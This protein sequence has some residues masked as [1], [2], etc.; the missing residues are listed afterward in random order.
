M[1]V[2][3]ALAH[4]VQT[5]SKILGVRG[6]SDYNGASVLFFGSMIRNGA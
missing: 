6:V 1:N 2:L 5:S 3:V 4:H